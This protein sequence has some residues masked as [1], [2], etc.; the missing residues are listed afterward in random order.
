MPPSKLRENHDERFLVYAKKRHCPKTVRNGLNW[1]RAEARGTELSFWNLRLFLWQ[2]DRRIKGV[3]G[4]LYPIFLILKSPKILTEFFFGGIGSPECDLFRFSSTSHFWM[5]T[6]DFRRQPL[7]DIL[8]IITSVSSIAIQH[9]CQ[10]S[11]GLKCWIWQ[12][13]VLKTAMYRSFFSPAGQASRMAASQL[14]ELRRATLLRQFLTS[15]YI[16]L[17]VHEAHMCDQSHRNTP[18]ARS[19]PK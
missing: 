8:N 15:D 4:V 9:F 19:D 12:C 11:E 1:R 18:C 7:Q 6:S 10:S 16:L 3:L 14:S 17:D 13:F 5:H 2:T